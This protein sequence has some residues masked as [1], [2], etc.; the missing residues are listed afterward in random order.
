M[1]VI[2]TAA[3]TVTAVCTVSV[4]LWL[5]HTA[6]YVE[7]VGYSIPPTTQYTASSVVELSSLPTDQ[8]SENLSTISLLL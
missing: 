2:R 7:A 8:K 3:V 6:Q 4:L 5:H 1:V